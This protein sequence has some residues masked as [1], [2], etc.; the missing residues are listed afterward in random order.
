MKYRLTSSMRMRRHLLRSLREAVKR[1]RRLDWK[2]DLAL[3]K[4][5]PTGLCPGTLC[6]NVKRG[7][8]CG[9]PTSMRRPR[10][11]TM[12]KQTTPTHD[13]R[14]QGRGSI[15]A[16]RRGYGARRIIPRDKAARPGRRGRRPLRLVWCLTAGVAVRRRTGVGAPYDL[17]GAKP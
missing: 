17:V 5:A 13:K 7:A 8:Y 14:P 2:P 3:A 11:C 10:I 15:P 6:V 4:P 9:A 12:F 1:L 16:R